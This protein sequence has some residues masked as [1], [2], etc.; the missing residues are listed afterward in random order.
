MSSSNH[1]SKLTAI[2]SN[3]LA[4]IE[5]S[6]IIVYG[7]MRPI[8]PQLLQK[9]LPED[10]MKTILSNYKY[11]YPDCA[12]FNVKIFGRVLKMDTNMIV[13]KYTNSG[14]GTCIFN[15]PIS[16]HDGSVHSIS[17][18]LRSIRRGFM[19][20]F[21]KAISTNY[22][23]AIG[24]SQN[25]Y[26][27]VGIHV[28]IGGYKLKLYNQNTDLVGKDLNHE[29]KYVFYATSTFKMIFDFVNDK[30]IICHQNLV[31][32]TIESEDGDVISL[33]GC[34]LLTPAFTLFDKNDC[35]EIIQWNKGYLE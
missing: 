32:D 34:K 31:W 13:R 15:T 7:F 4:P 28:S 6:I 33:N 12:G 30:M 35:I 3:C 16:G 11:K 27:S 14:C 25:K 8:Q 18:K 17:I 21:K 26:C 23:E 29:Y 19:M 9:I 1:P 5:L 22:D 10:I 20:G 24:R 2:K